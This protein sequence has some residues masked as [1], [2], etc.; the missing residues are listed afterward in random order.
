[1][2][3]IARKPRGDFN[4]FVV[5]ERED[6]HHPFVSA[7]VNAIS[8]RSGEWFWGNYFE[9]KDAAIE[10]FNGRSWPSI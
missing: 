5:I 3:I 10:H 8:L 2:K 9:K 7:T 4:E 1:M 6:R